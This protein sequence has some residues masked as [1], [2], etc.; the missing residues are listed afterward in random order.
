MNYKFG[1][2]LSDKQIE[3]L[4][5]EKIYLQQEAKKH[6]NLLLN[7][8]NAKDICF[9]PSLKMIPPI[10]PKSNPVSRYDINHWIFAINYE[11]NLIKDKQILISKMDDILFFK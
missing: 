6:V 8:K 9:F 3:L 5:N 11:L 4:H 7:Y 10:I 1:E 2:V